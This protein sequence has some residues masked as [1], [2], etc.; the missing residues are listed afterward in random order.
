MFFDRVQF[1][2]TW[3]GEKKKKKCRSLIHHLRPVHLLVSVSR[4]REQLIL[5][6]SLFFPESAW[7]HIDCAFAL[8]NLH[9][10]AV[11]Q[12][13]RYKL[14]L[15][16]YKS[17]NSLLPSYLSDLSPCTVCRTLHSAG[18]MTRLSV[19]RYRLEHYGKHVFSIC[20][21]SLEL[22]LLISAKL[23]PQTLS[24]IT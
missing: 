5:A 4:P 21:F 22:C 12:R 13:I 3:A 7:W 9:W 8:K 24:K 18:I 14:S 23:T 19:P 6:V 1:Q 10:L 15:L 11:C 20:T 2:L 16:C 17:F